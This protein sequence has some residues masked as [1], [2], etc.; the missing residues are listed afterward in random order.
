MAKPRKSLTAVLHRDLS[1]DRDQSI[2][3]AI[4][5]ARKNGLDAEA[6]LRVVEQASI[7]EDRRERQERKRQRV[8]EPLENVRPEPSMPDLIDRLIDAEQIDYLLKKLA[9]EQRH[10]VRMKFLMG[11]SS[12]EIEG[13][14]GRP[15]GAIK[16]SI[17]YALD[18]M[19]R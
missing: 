16:K 8:T 9:E 3:L 19:R 12:R 15:K 4:A 18:R 7:R 17:H 13:V 1:R 2:H 5:R 10:L 6:I 11:M 14:T